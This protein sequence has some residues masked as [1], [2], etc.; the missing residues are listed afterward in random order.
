MTSM[1]PETH[2]HG[3]QAT[4]EGATICIGC[5]HVDDGFMHARDW[6]CTAPALAQEHDSDIV[7]GRPTG[8]GQPRCRDTNDGSCVHFEPC[9]VLPPWHE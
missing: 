9:R 6:T 8:G 3:E 5:E 4:A 1:T 2:E 7:T